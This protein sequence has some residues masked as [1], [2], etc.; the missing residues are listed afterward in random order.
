MNLATLRVEFRVRDCRGRRDRKR[1]LEEI[2]KRLRKHFNVSAAAAEGREADSAR[3]V[4]AAV[5]SLRGQAREIL[6]R[7]AEALAAHPDLELSECELRD[8]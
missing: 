1:R 8:L 4:A 5:G 7:V 3:L 6:E 2:V